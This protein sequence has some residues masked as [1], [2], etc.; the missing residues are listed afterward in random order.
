MS[1]SIWKIKVGDTTAYELAANKT[2]DNAPAWSPDGRWIVY[3]AEDGEGVN[4]M[5]LNVA[6]GESTAITTGKRLTVDPT[7]SPDGKTLALYTE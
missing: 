3:T 6:T 1:G 2:Y 4:L 7:W 5:L